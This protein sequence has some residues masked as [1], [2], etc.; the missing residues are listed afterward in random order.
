[1]SRGKGV[2]M[3]SKLARGNPD[4]ARLV[5]KQLRNW[6]LARQQ[7]L[8]AVVST[9]RQAEDFVCISRQVGTPGER[10]AEGVGAA[11]GWPV[12]GRQVLEAM[13]GDDEQR[14]NIYASMDERDLGWWEET[15]RSLME[16]DFVR[17]DYFHRLCETLLSLATQANSVFV[18]R[19][20]DLVLPKDRGFRL[21]LVA[22]EEVRLRAF[23]A[24]LGQDVDRARIEMQ[25]I[26]QE[27]RRFFRRH[28]GVDPDDP[29]RYD[30]TI[31]LARFSV[32]EA[33]ELILQARSIRGSGH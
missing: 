28:F 29:L 12:F 20:A 18:G 7:K 6:E 1:M 2:K 5:E 9:P 26:Q 30:M 33:V 32:E 8:T 31:N 11:L 23:A 27:R 16:S 22:P 10:V 4:I 3:A 13:A 15:L 25:R 21:R 17:N 24:A 19:G 14:R